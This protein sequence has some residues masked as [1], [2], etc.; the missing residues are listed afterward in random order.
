[1][2][3]SAHHSG[4]IPWIRQS[5]GNEESPVYIKD[6]CRSEFENTGAR[7]STRR[8]LMAK[9][10]RPRTVHY[11]RSSLPI[12]RMDVSDE[13]KRL[14]SVLDESAERLQYLCT[15]VQFCHFNSSF[16][17]VCHFSYQCRFPGSVAELLRRAATFPRK[18]YAFL[19]DHFLHFFSTF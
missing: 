19:S 11:S 6:I 9:R 13:Q 16:P 2:R 17:R 8:F 5:S 10:R 1:M 14:V 3:N 15:I 18:R 7:Q 4:A 12:R